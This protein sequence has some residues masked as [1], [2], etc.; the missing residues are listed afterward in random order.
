MY[1]VYFGSIQPIFLQW[2]MGLVENFYLKV[3]VGVRYLDLHHRKIHPISPD[4]VY[5]IY[6]M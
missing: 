1:S 5:I 2:A 4:Q 6:F 3:D